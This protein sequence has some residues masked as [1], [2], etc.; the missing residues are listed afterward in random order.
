MKRLAKTEILAV[1]KALPYCQVEAVQEN[2]ILVSC[3]YNGVNKLLATREAGLCGMYFNHNYYLHAG[4]R[5]KG[6]LHQAEVFWEPAAPLESL[7]DF[8]NELFHAVEK[9]FTPGD[10]QA[11]VTCDMDAP[12]LLALAPLR[13]GSVWGTDG[14]SVG[15]YS[16][17][18]H[19]QYVLNKAGQGARFV[20]AL[21]KLPC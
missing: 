8:L 17:V 15:G 4:L 14:G 20:A 2:K 5:T 16:A 12:F 6:K 10:V 3:D 1:L 7:D 11:F 9:S 18:K 13:G 19:G 21:A